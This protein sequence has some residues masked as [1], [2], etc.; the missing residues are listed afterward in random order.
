MLFQKPHELVTSH[1][2]TSSAVVIPTSRD[3]GSPTAFGLE[4]TFSFGNFGSI[5]PVI[6]CIFIH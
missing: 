5:S 4:G 6:V 1:F 3:A 2:N